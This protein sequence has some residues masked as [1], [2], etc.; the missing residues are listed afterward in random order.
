MIV[1]RWRIVGVFCSGGN[2]GWMVLNWSSAGVL[3]KLF[4]F[5]ALGVLGLLMW[6]PDVI[7]LKD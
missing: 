7:V 3:D 1:S 5:S 6:K 2:F 4:G